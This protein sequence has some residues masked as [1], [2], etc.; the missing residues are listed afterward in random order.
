MRDAA[1]GWV[2]LAVALH[3]ANQVARG[4]G[5]CAAIRL[6][7]PDDAR[8]RRR[9]VVAAWVAGAGIGGVLSARGGDVAWLVLL[10]RRLAG[11]GYPPLAGTLVAEGPARRSSG[12][13]SLP[14]CS[15]PGSTPG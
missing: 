8:P 9:D 13:C 4:C 7:L 10:R 6:A 12:V 2:A 1:F 14:W 5:W 11:E 15:R 3:L